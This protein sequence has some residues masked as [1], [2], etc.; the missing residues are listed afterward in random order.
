MHITMDN[1]RQTALLI[2][3]MLKTGADKTIRH[4][5]RLAG[6]SI[7]EAQ[8]D[9]VEDLSGS[10]ILVERGGRKG[11]ITAAHNIRLKRKSKQEIDEMEMY[12]LIAM[13]STRRG[14][15]GMEGI[16]I[17]LTGTKILGGNPRDGKGPDIAW[18]PLSA[19]KAAT[20]GDRSGVF[21]RM[22]DDK[23]PRMVQEGDNEVDLQESV[24][25]WLVT[26]FSTEQETI[27]LTHDERA[28]IGRTQS[29]GPAENE[30]KENGWDYERRCIDRPSERW[31][32][33]KRLDE[34]MPAR[35]REA[36]PVHPEYMGGLS[37]AGVWFLWQPAENQEMQEVRHQLAG[38]IYFQDSEKG[39]HGETTM[40]NHGPRSLNRI[41]DDHSCRA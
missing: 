19:D 9:T 37:G 27:A 6:A 21:Y 38:M 17:E 32:E 22:D 11:I 18:I 40:I 36:L 29:I 41:I 34:N 26:G 23:R 12:V 7:E 39:E 8:G 20:I 33:R 1:E 24:G 28:V 13:Y 3:A 30:W 16:K 14:N 25:G 4:T 15:G 35:V 2:E 5:V 31:A 10:G